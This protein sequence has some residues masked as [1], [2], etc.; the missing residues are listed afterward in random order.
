MKFF[1]DF[2]MNWVILPSVW[3][4]K[5]YALACLRPA[6]CPVETDVGL[7]VLNYFNIVQW[8]KLWYTNLEFCY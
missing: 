8:E 5:A 1:K 4:V 2:Y 6:H 3:V 7:I